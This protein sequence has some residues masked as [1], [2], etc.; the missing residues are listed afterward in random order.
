MRTHLVAYLAR[1]RDGAEHGVA[2]V[3]SARDQPS[4]HECAAVV[5]GY[6]IGQYL[7]AAPE[8]E[9]NRPGRRSA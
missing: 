3:P 4:W 8:P 9:E 5:P 2:R 1:T 6:L 7:G